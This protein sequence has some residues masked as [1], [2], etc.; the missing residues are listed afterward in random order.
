MFRHRTAASAAFAG[1]VPLLLAGATALTALGAGPAY[2]HG[3]PTDPLS[4][5]AACGPDGG[6]AASSD[7]CRAAVAAN[8]GR[9]FDDWDNLRLAGV[10]GRDRESIPDG[11]L[12]SGGL[13]A[14][15]GLDVTRADWPA[16]TLRAGAAFTMTYRS[17]IPHEGSFSL[18]LTRQGYA[19]GTALTW[20]DL[21]PEPFATARDPQL[22]GG[23]YRI[24]G[25]LPTDRTGRHVLYTIWRNTS[26]PDTYYSCSD[27]VFPGEA[28]DEDGQAGAVTPEQPPSFAPRPVTT[29]PTHQHT[30]APSPTGLSP[31]APSATPS[32]VETTAR[33]AAGVPVASEPPADDTA[34]AARAADT[35]PVGSPSEIVPMAAGGAAILAGIGVF[36]LRKRRVR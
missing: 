6:A 34:S 22:E 31:T 15:K 2:A 1:T 10:D 24:S 32:P 3:A 20:D 11:R 7:A 14:F 13:D 26:T 17:T 29:L 28:A 21:A 33:A 5:A 25:T 16:T 19:P 4:R 35:V 36:L 30:P 9:A 8:D 23:A 12:C 18:Y 27:V